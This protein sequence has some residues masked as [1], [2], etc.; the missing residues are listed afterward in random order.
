MERTTRNAAALLT[1][2]AA[3]ALLVA[4]A[5]LGDTHTW[6]DETDFEGGQYDSTVWDSTTSPTY[7]VLLSPSSTAF[8]AYTVR[9][10]NIPVL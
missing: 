1:L 10:M 3:L 9:Y 7:I 8:G 4:G 2:A 6:D 5:A